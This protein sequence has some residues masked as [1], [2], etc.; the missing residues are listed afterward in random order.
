[1]KKVTRKQGNFKVY[2][3]LVALSLIALAGCTQVPPKT[4]ESP[5]II[6]PT[7]IKLPPKT[8][9]PTKIK[10]PPKTKEPSPITFPIKSSV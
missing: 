4:I 9:E 6:E 10:T 2:T 3:V 1:M 5:K 7:K 8:I